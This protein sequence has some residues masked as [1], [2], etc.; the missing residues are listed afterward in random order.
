VV[1]GR[2]YEL[3][4]RDL[5]AA[6]E[7]AALASPQGLALLRAA[8]RQGEAELAHEPGSERR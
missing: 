4:S 2:D 1:G 6:L 7:G 8:I 5:A 3:S